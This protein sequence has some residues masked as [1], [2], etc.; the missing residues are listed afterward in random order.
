MFCFILSTMSS[1]TYQQQMEKVKQALEEKRRELD[2]FKE[3]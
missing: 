3:R 1:F 2:K